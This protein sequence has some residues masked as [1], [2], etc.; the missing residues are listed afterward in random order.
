MT[1]RSRS[2]CCRPILT[3]AA[4]EASKASRAA[5]CRRPPSGDLTSGQTLPTQSHT[6]PADKRFRLLTAHVRATPSTRDWETPPSMREQRRVH[7]I[8]KLRDRRCRRQAGAF[9]ARGVPV[10]GAGPVTTSVDPGPGF[11]LTP[12]PL[13]LLHHLVA[14]YLL[15][16]SKSASPVGWQTAPAG[17]SARQVC[18]PEMQPSA[19]FGPVPANLLLQPQELLPG[20]VEH[21]SEGRVRRFEGRQF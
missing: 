4:T 9:E 2:W 14:P 19:C 6:T 3:A 10:S 18:P 8:V 11:P 21:V 16:G 1:T 13:E 12:G 20:G 5:R 7:G 17:N 15:R